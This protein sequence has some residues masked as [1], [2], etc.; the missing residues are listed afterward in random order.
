MVNTIFAFW[1][2]L[3]KFALTEF[4]LCEGLVYA[5]TNISPWLF[6]RLLLNPIYL[7]NLS[8]PMYY[9]QCLLMFTQEN[10]IEIRLDYHNNEVSSKTNIS[11]MTFALCTEMPT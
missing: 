4:A 1:H 8:K 9:I 2:Q 3:N 5:R 6:K 10:V 11:E 7:S